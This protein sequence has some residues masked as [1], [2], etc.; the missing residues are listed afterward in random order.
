M[1]QLNEIEIWRE[2]RN[3]LL[4][5]AKDEPLAR[6]HRAE[7]PKKQ[8]PFKGGVKRRVAL[9]LSTVGLAVFLAAGAAYALDIQCQ[10]GSNSVGNECLG[11][12]ARD[13]MDGTEGNDDIRGLGDNDV[14][15]GLGGI[16]A[17]EGDDQEVSLSRQG[18]DEVLGGTGG[19]DLI[20]RDGSD[21]LSGGRGADSIDALEASSNGGV[22]TVNG[23][24]GNDQVFA[25]DGQRDVIDCGRG[26]RDEIRHDVGIDKIKNCEIKDTL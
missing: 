17:L 6:R 23:G 13:T 9:L 12:D 10:P 3:E 5:E 22:D 18:D 2:H 8:D 11:T 7:R 14:V 16:D 26:A 4:M 21:L 20:G 1:Y 15:R 24:K 25:N 19:D